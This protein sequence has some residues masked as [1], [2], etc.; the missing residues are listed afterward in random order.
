MVTTSNIGGPSI[1]LSSSSKKARTSS[2][3]SPSR[4]KSKAKL[5]LDRVKRGRRSKVKRLGEKRI[6]MMGG[7]EDQD[8]PI[9][10]E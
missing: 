1:P 3:G 2:L 4:Y 8:E 7:G 6:E 9:V 5:V 10:L